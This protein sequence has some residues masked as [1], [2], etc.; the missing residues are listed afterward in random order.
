MPLDLGALM[1]QAQKLQHDLQSAQEQAK[2]RSVEASA[3]GGM[4]TAVVTGAMELRKL[5]I[6]PACGDPK[7]LGMLQDLVIAAVNQAL[8]RASEMMQEEMR[9]ATGGMA[10]P[11]GIL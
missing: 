3:G 11:P 10:L 7:D 8:A 5:T 1:Q 9:K 4:V 6:D 2:T